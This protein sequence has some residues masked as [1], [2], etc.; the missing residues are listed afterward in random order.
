VGIAV[1][2][3]YGIVIACYPGDLIWAK[4]CI[5]TLRASGVKWPIALIFDGVAAH[6][7][8]VQALIQE[9]FVE[10]VLDRTTVSDPWLRERSFGWGFTKMIAFWESPW[11]YFV[12]LDADT[13]VSGD[14]TTLFTDMNEFD[15]VLDEPEESSD[16]PGINK[17]FFDLGRVAV[18]YPDFDPR[19]YRA[20][21][22][23]TGVFAARRGALQ[24]EDYRAA[25]AAHLSD[26]QIY[27]FGGEMGMLNL[28]IFLGHQRGEL[29]FRQRRIQMLTA[30]HDDAYLQQR[31]E[32]ERPWV[33][34][35]AGSKPLAIGSAFNQPMTDGRR[36]VA[37]SLGCCL[38]LEDLRFRVRY[39]L[40]LVRKR[41]RRFVGI[42]V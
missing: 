40:F 21:Y 1:S 41:L 11:E 13:A 8:D 2:V 25:M 34:H 6:H 14:I 15:F 38:A 42:R 28:L 26:A 37:D 39:I 24:M 12:Y 22:F 7:Q 33:F 5:G 18:H 16:D 17:W 3:E 4:G 31:L 27:R 30:D 20:N 35:Y 9:G 19:A 36:L 32:E 23:C 10:Q 29:T